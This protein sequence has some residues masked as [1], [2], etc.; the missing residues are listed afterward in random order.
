MNRVGKLLSK[1]DLCVPKHPLTRPANFT[2]KL[3]HSIV[4]DVYTVDSLEK[5]NINPC[6]R[7]YLTYF[8]VSQKSDYPRHF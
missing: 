5:F 8:D 7:Q 4:V 2:L 3:I 6:P 1:R